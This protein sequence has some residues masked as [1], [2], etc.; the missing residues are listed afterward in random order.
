M[1]SALGPAGTRMGRAGLCLQFARRWVGHDRDR[2][3]ARLTKATA[4]S[5]RLAA[6]IVVVGVVTG[7]G[8]VDSSPASVSSSQSRATASILESMTLNEE[9]I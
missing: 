2:N 5:G 1:R 9:N 6:T 4:N 8:D 7:S 3:D